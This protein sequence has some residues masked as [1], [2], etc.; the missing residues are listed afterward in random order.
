MVKIESSWGTQF[1][2][3]GFYQINAGK[4]QIQGTLVSHSIRFHSKQQKFCCLI[5]LEFFQKTCNIKL[6]LAFYDAVINIKRKGK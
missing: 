3:Q 6:L 2:C 1:Y 5:Q 4:L